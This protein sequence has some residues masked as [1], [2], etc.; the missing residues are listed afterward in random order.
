MGY[1]CWFLKLWLFLSWLRFYFSNADKFL[2]YWHETG[3]S[4]IRSHGS[5]YNVTISHVI[6]RPGVACPMPDTYVTKYLEHEF[7]NALCL[8][9]YIISKVLYIT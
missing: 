3:C 1:Q 6:K 8:V 4:Y 5:K 2:V 7:R 9:T